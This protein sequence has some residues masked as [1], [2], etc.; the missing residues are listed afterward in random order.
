MKY[1]EAHFDMTGFGFQPVYHFTQ[2][3]REILDRNLAFVAVENLHETRHVGALEVVRQADIHVEDG[4][5][6]LDAADLSS[7]LTG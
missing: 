3:G 1:G 5:R 4:D 2:H 7:T 6:M